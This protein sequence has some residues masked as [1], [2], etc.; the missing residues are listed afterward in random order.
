MSSAAAAPARDNPFL[1]DVPRSTDPLHRSGEAPRLLHSSASSFAAVA[2]K[3]A[4]HGTEVVDYLSLLAWNRCAM[5]VVGGPARTTI[6]TL[7]THQFRGLKLVWVW[8][9]AVAL[10]W[11]CVRVVRSAGESRAAMV[12]S[13]RTG[14]AVEGNEG[15]TPASALGAALNRRFHVS[16]YTRVA[17]AFTYVA[18]WAW[19]VALLGSLPSEE[20]Y[21]DLA[22]VLVLSMAF[23]LTAWAGQRGYGPL[24]LLLRAR[25]GALSVGIDSRDDL[26]CDEVTVAAYEGVTL[27]CEWILAVAWVGVLRHGSDIL[28]DNDDRQSEAGDQGAAWLVAI[29]AVAAR[30]AF[31]V[32]LTVRR[33]RRAAAA[34]AATSAA[35][36]GAGDDGGE[37]LLPASVASSLSLT[38]ASVDALRRVRSSVEVRLGPGIQVV[39]SAKAMLLGA[40][41]FTTGVALNA[42]AQTSWRAMFASWGKGAVLPAVMYAAALSSVTVAGAS[43]RAAHTREY[44]D[45]GKPWEG[46][47]DDSVGQEGEGAGGGGGGCCGALREVGTRRVV[48]ELCGDEERVG[49]FIAGFVWNTAFV[50]SC[51]QDVVEDWR[52]MIAAL[53]TFAAAAVNVLMEW[54]GVSE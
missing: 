6:E 35:D 34:S 1:D 27:C 38:P 11:V 39:R 53:L 23:A 14:N 37:A 31:I 40:F 15:A 50:V 48:A 51:G 2:R 20:F 54:A 22:S 41:A 10:S 18:M 46:G 30:A 42:A 17:G 45:G 32:A 43:Y 21:Q 3:C 13:D 7:M 5:G 33:H 24:K 4:K 25:T 36:A 44:V 52:W 12:A 19:A 26:A 8:T 28:L 49:G 29:V 16:M 9:Y 47:G